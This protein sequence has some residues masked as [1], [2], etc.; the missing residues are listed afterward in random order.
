MRHHVVDLNEL[1]E[2]AGSGRRVAAPFADQLLVHELLRQRPPNVYATPSNRRY[3]FMRSIRHGLL[4]AGA[5]FL[6][7]GLAWGG[8]DFVDALDFKQRSD[9]AIRKAQFYSARYEMARER[10]PKTPVESAEIQL[11][12]EI[13]G[14]LRQYKTSPREMMRLLGGRLVHFPQVQLDSLVWLASTNPNAQLEDERGGAA[15]P[16]AATGAPA[17]ESGVAYR[18]YQIAQINGRLSPF[19]G[20]FRK[21]IET[22]DA[23]ADALRAEPDVRDVQVLSLP[24]DISSSAS[25]QGSSASA[26]S[27]AVF[28]LKIVLGI[29][30]EA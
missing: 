26:K 10:L 8:M 13:A 9:A 15:Q 1:L 25:L 5:A 14:T 27:E 23:L 29:G 24:L 4:A 20:D 28:S 19:D 22:I 6:L 7:G 12:V 18:H 30:H 21:A 11:A 2:K 17:G 3:S 16:A